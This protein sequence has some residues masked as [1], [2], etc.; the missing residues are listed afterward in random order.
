[1]ISAPSQGDAAHVIVAADDE[2]VLVGLGAGLGVNRHAAAHVR[3]KYLNFE[4]PPIILHFS[5]SPHKIIN[6]FE[7]IDFSKICKN[8]R[9]SKN[10]Q[11]HY[12]CAISGAKFIFENLKAP[13]EDNDIVAVDYDFRNGFMYWVDGTARKVYR[14]DASATVV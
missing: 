11:R 12:L 7:N 10:R 3:F 9:L 6:F 14:Y 8:A 13:D 1:M 4:F 5:K 2:L